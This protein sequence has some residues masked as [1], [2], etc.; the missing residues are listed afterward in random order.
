MLKDESSLAD[1]GV[2]DRGAAV[3]PSSPLQRRF[4]PC[5]GYQPCLR[6]RDPPLALL[7]FN[8][9]DLLISLFLDM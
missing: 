4:A 2:S 7:H 1:A 6:Q 5:T 9:R 3:R 8:L